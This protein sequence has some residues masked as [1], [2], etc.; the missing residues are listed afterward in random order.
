MIVADIS[1]H[2]GNGRAWAAPPAQRVCDG[3]GKPL[4]DANGK[5]RWTPFITFTSKAVRDAWSSAILEAIQTQ[6][7][8]VL[9]D[10]AEPDA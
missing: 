8:E 3:D 6:D 9:A 7:P 1:I 2:V 4:L 10:A 5:Q